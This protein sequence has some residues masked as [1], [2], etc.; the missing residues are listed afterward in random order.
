MGSKEIQGDPRGSKGIQVGFN[1]SLKFP[2]QMD[3]M[4]TQCLTPLLPVVNCALAHF[5]HMGE[6]ARGSK[7][8]QGDPSGFLFIFEIP[9]PSGPNGPN[10]HTV[11]L[12]NSTAA[13]RQ[14]CLGSFSTYGGIRKG[15]QGDPW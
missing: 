8:I 9:L 10:E 1:L 15:I 13:F 3:Q 6:F 7:G 11:S 2:C 14:L 12:A 4:N 5:Q